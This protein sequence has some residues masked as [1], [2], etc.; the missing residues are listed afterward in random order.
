MPFYFVSAGTVLSPHKYA[1]SNNVG[2]IN[3]ENVTVSDSALGGYAWSTNK[4]FIKFN[5]AQGGVFNDG[6]GNLSG[7]AWGEQLGWIDFDTVFIS[8]ST[9]LFSGTATGALVGTITFDCPNYCDVETDWR[10]ATSS[11][12]PPPTVISNGGGG[13]LGSI[14][15]QAASVQTS[16]TSNTPSEPINQTSPITEQSTDVAPTEQNNTSIS[17]T[18]TPPLPVPVEAPPLFDVISE[19]AQITPQ[20]ASPLVTPLTVVGLLLFVFAVLILRKVGASNQ[21]ETTQ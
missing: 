16:P 21:N 15:V 5:P 8:P 1:W 18:E 2:Y 6:T 12:T 11:P 4:G 10:P 13:I 17:P 14:G 3:F 20:G 7:S 19:P 9:G